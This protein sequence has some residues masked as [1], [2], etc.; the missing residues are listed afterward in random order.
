M[1]C[2]RIPSFKH[3]GLG[4]NPNHTPSTYFIIWLTLQFFIDLKKYQKI[5]K[6][7]VVGPLNKLTSLYRPLER[8][9]WRTAEPMNPLPPRAKILLTFF[10]SSEVTILMTKMSKN[11]FFIFLKQVWSKFWPNDLLT[12][13]KANTWLN[14]IRFLIAKRCLRFIAMP[15]RSLA[16]LSCNNFT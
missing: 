3:C 9:L 5:E 15:A 2:L 10:S 13:L 1:V 16:E 8:R 11:N 4:L 12:L 7:S 6:E 14:W